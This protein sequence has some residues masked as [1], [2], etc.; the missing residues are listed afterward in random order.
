MFLF[1]ASTTTPSG[2]SLEDVFSLIEALG[3]TAKP[4]PSYSA[5]MFARDFPSLFPREISKPPSPE[6]ADPPIAL[7]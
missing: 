2:Y 3:R 4:S 5:E 7:P 1:L 6:T